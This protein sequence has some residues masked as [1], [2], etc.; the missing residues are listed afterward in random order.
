MSAR[1]HPPGSIKELMPKVCKADAWDTLGHLSPTNWDLIRRLQEKD[2][3]SHPYDLEPHIWRS[4][5][6]RPEI[7]QAMRSA[8][9]GFIRELGAHL[10]VEA[11]AQAIDRVMRRAE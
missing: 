1:R 9:L 11:A 3:I 4:G 7:A 6:R 2:N 8:G 5:H 10:D